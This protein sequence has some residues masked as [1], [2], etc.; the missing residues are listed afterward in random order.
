MAAALTKKLKENC[1]VNVCVSVCEC[2]KVC[3]SGSRNGR[4][5]LSLNSC[6]RRCK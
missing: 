2:V 3:E 4:F 5:E 1:P 6:R